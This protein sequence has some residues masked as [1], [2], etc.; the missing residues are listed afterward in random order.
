MARVRDPRLRCRERTGIAAAGPHREERLGGLEALLSA[1]P[2]SDGGWTS[3]RLPESEADGETPEWPA[4][5]PGARARVHRQTSEAA[6]AR[7]PDQGVANYA[8]WPAALEGRTPRSHRSHHAGAFWGRGGLG[9]RN[10]KG[11]RP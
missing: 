1:H 5:I 10:R 8:R 3:G 4:P 11:R 7:R 6:G 9:G 2:V